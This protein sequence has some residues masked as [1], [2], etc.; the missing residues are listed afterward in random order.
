[1][2][3]SK[4][5]H[6]RVHQRTT[7]APENETSVSRLDYLE[8]RCDTSEEYYTNTDDEPIYGNGQGAG[9]SP[10]QWGMLGSVILRAQDRLASKAKFLSPNVKSRRKS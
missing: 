3:C 5:K 7:N 8:G 1:M 9:D 10:N 4:K 6:K 2:Q